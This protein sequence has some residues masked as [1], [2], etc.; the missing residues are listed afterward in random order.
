MNIFAKILATTLPFVFCFLLAAVGTTYYFSRAAITTLAESWL[1]T[2]LVEAVKVAAGQDEMLRRYGLENVP[3]SVFKAKLDADR[4]MSGIRIGESGMILG[5]DASGIVTVHPDSAM[6]GRDVSAEAWFKTLRPGR[7]HLLYRTAQG[8][9]L[10]VSDYFEPWR[11][12]ILAIDPEQ[13]VFSGVNRMRPY[14]FG[15]AVAG[16]IVLAVVLM[17][18]TRRWTEPLRQLTH[19]AERIG[20]GDLDMRITVRS[21]DEFG[22][23]SRVFNQMA[24]QLRK[25]LTALK[26]REA[27]FRSL[28]ENAADM[29]VILDAEGGVQYASPSTERLLGYPPD[30]LAGRRA[31]DLVHPDDLALASERFDHRRETVRPTAPMECR[32]RH[33]NGSWVTFEATGNNLLEDPAV[34]GIVVNAR[35]I[36]ARKA[37]ETALQRAYQELETR[38]ADRTAELFRTNAQLRQEINEREQMGEEKERLQGQLLQAQK[39]EAIGTLAGGIAHDFNNLLMGIQGNVDVMA[40]DLGAEHRHGPRLDTIRDCVSS[41]TRLTQQLLGFARLGKYEVKATDPNAL[42]AKSAD[43]FGRTRQELRV[44]ATYQPDVW[45]ISVDRGQLEQVLLNLLINAWQAMPKGG[46]IFLETANAALTNDQVR[47][48]QAVPGNFVRISVA[49]TGIGMD[50]TTMERIFDP[51]FTTKTMTRGTGLGLASAYGIVRNHGG[52]IE[53]TSEIGRGSVFSVY[54]KAVEAPRVEPAVDAARPHQGSE[55]ILV[56]DD[57][58]LIVDVGQAMLQT[59]GYEVL[60]AGSGREA[61]S[62]YREQRNRIDLVILDMVMPDMGGGQTFDQLKA[63]DADIKVLLA[64]GYSIN[65]Q[66]SEILARGCRGFIQKPFDLQALS[67]KVRSVLDRGA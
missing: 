46:T 11:W 16:F 26:H 67:E 24:R 45:T 31:F 25:S 53:V 19:G 33:V 59:L 17:L 41:G 1:A 44:V 56:V 5:V 28:I 35:D 55:T 18:L 34:R 4:I 10:A 38:V 36:T 3:A 61:V 48:H 54:L 7:Q 30:A 64:S 27:H 20:R 32:L 51:F 13:E 21:R 9:Q 42:V 62:I 12:Y 63:I 57:D 47:V 15:I 49:D 8:R 23:L 14:L 60:T 40:M 37:A 43:M 58:G 39:M 6:I 66:A 52:F 22:R 65:G 2:H 50:K 29:I